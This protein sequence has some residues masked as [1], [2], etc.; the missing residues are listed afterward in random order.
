MLSA[1]GT[2]L[3]QAQ[4]SMRRRSM[5]PST[6]S[7]I[8]ATIPISSGQIRMTFGRAHSANASAPP[9]SQGERV[10]SAAQT[11]SA[12]HVT[13]IVCETNQTEPSV[14]TCQCTL[15]IAKSSTSQSRWRASSSIQPRRATW[16]RIRAITATLIAP[17]MIE[18]KTVLVPATPNSATHGN[19]RIVASGRNATYH[20][21][22]CGV[23]SA[24]AGGSTKSRCPSRNAA[25]RWSKYAVL[26]ECVLS[27]MTA[28]APYATNAAPRISQARMRPGT[29]SR[30][31]VGELSVWSLILDAG[32]CVGSGN[33][34]GMMRAACLWE[35]SHAA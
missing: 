27:T 20:L 5:R 31:A 14:A 33:A 32:V 18:N 35:K 34:R 17:R 12:R 23:R 25:A 2:A 4:C 21:P 29:A 6:S 26:G 11:A 10:A 28:V 15:P 1:S 19:S 22:S 8:C 9:V 7:S 16:S 13:V 30:K 24:C 3:R